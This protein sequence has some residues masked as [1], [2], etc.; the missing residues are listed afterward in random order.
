VRLG[1]NELIDERSR[2]SR[3]RC[4]CL[5]DYER[6]DHLIWYCAKFETERR[7][8][9]DALNALVVQ[10]GTL[11]RDLCALMKWR[12]MKCCL[13]FLGSLEIRI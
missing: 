10:L 7:C 4:V 2:L 11:D 1:G 13:D 5:W 8:L 12:A 3:F 9:T 6:V